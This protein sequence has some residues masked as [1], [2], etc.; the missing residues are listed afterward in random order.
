M[1]NALVATPPEQQCGV[2]QRSYKSAVD[3]R[4]YPLQTTAQRLVAQELLIGVTGIA[5][6]ILVRFAFETL[7]QLVQCRRIIERVT[8][9]ERN[10]VEQYVIIDFPDDTP[11]YGIGQRLSGIGAPTVGIVTSGAGMAATGKVD[12]IAQ[13]VSVGYGLGKYIQNVEP[14]HRLCFTRSRSSAC[15][16]EFHVSRL[17]VR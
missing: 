8:A 14:L 16:A 9:R 15:L 13:P 3:K 6:Y 1:Q 4:I 10:A 2:V 12:G 17:P 5:P 11:Q 7:Q